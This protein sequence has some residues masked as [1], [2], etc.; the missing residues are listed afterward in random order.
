LHEPDSRIQRVPWSFVADADWRNTMIARTWHGVVPLETADAYR[1]YLFR[2]GVPELR[3]TTGNL[4]V[5]VL[6]R[7][8]GTQAHFLLI[9]W[10][11]SRDAIRAFAGDDV[12]RARYYPEDAGYL[13]E[14]EPT[15]THYEVL[16]DPYQAKGEGTP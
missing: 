12:E 16:D 3:A 4:G 2:T 7:T 1:G 8:E 5:H 6:R 13:L 15:V 9:S 11:D 10:W 14:L